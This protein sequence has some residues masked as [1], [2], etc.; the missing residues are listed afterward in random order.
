MDTLIDF[1]SSQK[2]GQLIHYS[3]ASLPE[4][5]HKLYKPPS[6]AGAMVSQT[7]LF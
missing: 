6:N 4:L 5:T 2:L 1:Q 7:E 3:T